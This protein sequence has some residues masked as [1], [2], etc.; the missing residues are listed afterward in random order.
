VKDEEQQKMLKA[1]AKNLLENKVFQMTLT[2]LADRALT[3]MKEHFTKSFETVELRT[4]DYFMVR[5]AIEDL[6]IIKAKIE[7][8]ANKQLNPNKVEEKE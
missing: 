1:Q 7:K 2:F 3:M 5:A 6:T 8:T 4:Q